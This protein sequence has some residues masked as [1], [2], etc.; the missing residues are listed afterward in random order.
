MVRFQ[1]ELLTVNINQFLDNNNYNNNNNNRS[2]LTEM[3]YAM[4]KMK[5][6]KKRQM[7]KCKGQKPLQSSI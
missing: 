4:K 7:Q 5:P 1:I 6:V 2:K 3:A